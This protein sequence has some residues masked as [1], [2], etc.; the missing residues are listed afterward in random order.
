MSCALHSLDSKVMECCVAFVN[1]FLGSANITLLTPPPPPHVKRQAT[2]NKSSFGPPRHLSHVPERGT[3]DTVS[4]TADIRHCM[5]LNG[6]CWACS[7]LQNTFFHWARLFLLDAFSYC[8]FVFLTFLSG[9][10]VA[11]VHCSLGLKQRL[12][13]TKERA[14][15]ERGI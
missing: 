12:P 2:V 6:L 15:M 11:P 7:P 1:D 14:K 4:V 9:H 8:H 10:V 3:V 5:L 13:P